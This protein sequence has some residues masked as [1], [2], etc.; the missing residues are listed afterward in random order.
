MQI[1]WIVLTGALALTV[2]VLLLQL[3]SL[4]HALR[5]LTD[6]LDE[7]LRTDTNTLI[8]LSSGDR[9]ARALAAR[10]NGQ[11]RALRAERL[12]LQM[13]DAR[14]KADVANVCYDLRTPL[15]AVCGYLDLLSQEELPARAEQYLAVIRERTNALR[16]LTEEMLRY[17]VAAST[18]EQLH[19]EPVCLNDVLEESLA[20]L[21]AVLTER[22]IA[23]SVS[24]PGEK[25]IR[26]LDRQALRRVLDNIL[27]NAARYSD[28]DLVVELSPGG[29]IAF[30]NGARSL[31]RVQ[32]ERLFDR[33]F[34]VQSAGGSTGLGLSI[35]R[36]LTEKMG[37][38]VSAAC[39]EGR[40]R[41]RVEFP[42]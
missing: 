28:G 5:E 20:G 2:L 12:R 15:T 25:V 24:L 42:A 3:C 38:R 18:A 31:G 36:L 32:A 19:I 22:G 21:Y 29:S 10:L 27:M 30:E 6:E 16:D 9:S 11:L 26:P 14:L 13:G 23:P 33:F 7:K 35:A 4:R 8:S 41:V 37:G 1:G 39:R 34:S 17:S 40:L